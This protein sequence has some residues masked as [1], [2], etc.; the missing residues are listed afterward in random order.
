MHEKPMLPGRSY[1]LKLSTQAVTATLAPLKYK[2]NVNTLEHVAARKLELNDIGVCGP[3]VSRPIVFEPYAENR[4]LGGFILVDRISNATVGAG[5]LHF[6]LRRSHNVH[7]QALDVEKAARADLKAQQPC[8]VWFTGLSGAGKSTIANLLEKQ[9]HAQGRH[10]CLLDG[11]N[12]RHGLNKD[13]GF[14]DADRV[15]NIR[16]VAEVA[17]LMVDAGLI[18]LVS[19]ISPF[20]AERRMARG[21]VE[22]NGFIEV[23]VDTP[24][25]VAESRDPKGLFKKARRGELKNF[26]GIDSPYE[27]P[28]H[29]EVQLD[30][31][32]LTAEQ[33]AAVILTEL[34]RRGVIDAE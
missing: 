13:L 24:L 7:W 33:A 25:A 9:L 22:T 30:T 2:V 14:S 15:E 18:V 6:A 4:D 34:Q 16:R 8:I 27:P 31:T 21:F 11:D 12:V 19:F 29:P 28:E 17:R 1:H 32:R 20:R 5:L 26:T 3:Q 23:F 10:T